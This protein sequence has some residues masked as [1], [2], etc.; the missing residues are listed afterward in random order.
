VP[1]LSLTALLLTGCDKDA[2]EPLAAPSAQIP[3]E[4]LTADLAGKVLAKVGGRTIT[5]GDYA[6]T[7]ER[8]DQ[9]ERRR[10]QTPERRLALLNEIITVELL[11]REAER[12]GLDKSA[13]AQEMLRQLLRD[14]MLRRQKNNLP[15]LED[16]PAARLH[17]YYDAHR[18]ELREPERRRVS[19]ILLHERSEAEQVLSQAK[20]ASPEQWG[21]LVKRY[22]L[23]KS[24]SIS[25]DKQDDKPQELTGDLGLV[26]APGSERGENLS[27]PEP[28]RKAL[29]TLNKVGQVYDG[30]VEYNDELHIVRLMGI[31]PERDRSFAEA[32][33]TIRVRVLQEIAEQKEAELIADL[34]KT[35]PVTINE[36]ALAQI[37]VPNEPKP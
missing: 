15:K 3:P 31:S 37:K 8:M 6:A 26:S 32:E 1:A 20:T 34:K 27:V 7:L 10:Y 22:S 5:L 19:H 11:A 35:I 17:E 36:A 9:F 25:A 23:D 33:R 30:L 16:L 21:D 14:E 2:A 13:E 29:F 24:S 18:N 12:R 28:V 4:Q